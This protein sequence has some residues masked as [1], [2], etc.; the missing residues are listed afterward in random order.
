MDQLVYLVLLI[1]C[2]IVVLKKF[3]KRSKESDDTEQE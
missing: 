3:T 1:I 2:S